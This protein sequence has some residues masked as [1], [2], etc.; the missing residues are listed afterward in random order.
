MTD[1]VLG[2]RCPQYRVTPEAN[3]AR[4]ACIPQPQRAHTEGCAC[5]LS[6]GRAVISSWD[7]QSLSW[8]PLLGDGSQQGGGTECRV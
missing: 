5:S 6:T 8:A 4:G 7:S 2:L 1:S 3:E